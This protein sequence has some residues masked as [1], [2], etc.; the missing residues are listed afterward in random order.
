MGGSR[1]TRDILTKMLCEEYDF[2]D[3]D[4]EGENDARDACKVVVRFPDRRLGIKFKEARIDRVSPDAKIAGVQE[5]DVFYSIAGELVQSAVSKGEPLTGLELD[6]RVMEMVVSRPDRPLVVEFIRNRSETS[7]S[8]TPSHNVERL[9]VERLTKLRDSKSKS[10]ILF[11][12]FPRTP[13]Q[14]AIAKRFGAEPDCYV[15]LRKSDESEEIDRWIL[16]AYTSILYKMD[17]G[18]SP[19]DIF[20]E[21]AALLNVSQPHKKRAIASKTVD[22]A[23]EEK[24]GEGEGVPGRDSSSSTPPRRANGRR[25]SATAPPS[26]HKKDASGRITCMKWTC[27]AVQVK[28]GASFVLPIDVPNVPAK[29]S[30]TF[31][32]KDGDIEFGV[33]QASS[34]RGNGVDLVASGRVDAHESTIAGSATID[35]AGEIRL[36]WDNAYSWFNGKTLSY[37]IT[38]DTTAHYERLKVV[39]KLQSKLKAVL[40]V[41]TLARMRQERVD[42]A[43]AAIQSR[44]RGI[45]GRQAARDWRS[46]LEKR[47]RAETAAKSKVANFLQ[48]RVRGATGRQRYARLSRD[49][50]LAK[51]RTRLSVARLHLEAL[52]RL[53]DRHKRSFTLTGQSAETKAR[54]MRRRVVEEEEAEDNDEGPRVGMLR[55]QVA[56]WQ[57]ETKLLGECARSLAAFQSEWGERLRGEI[58]TQQSAIARLEG[59]SGMSE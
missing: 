58:E 14:A 22:V 29:L 54:E 55:A 5:G 13:A 28:A 38:V 46:L 10:P 36:E 6:Q 16:D 40:A 20:A 34:V 27:A 7:T 39:K 59:M 37:E 47:L 53:C 41:T 8:T 2:E 48:R 57:L 25:L 32:T 3:V 18:M 12:S 44:I 4:G 33:V 49:R 21:I 52:N 23:D 51:A 1:K 15:Y 11:R 45:F 56:E 35:T 26:S 24:R 42:R 31:D 43:A 30:W 9:V 50:D 19:N 17:A